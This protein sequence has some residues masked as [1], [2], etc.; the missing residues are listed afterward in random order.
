MDYVELINEQRRQL[1]D[2]QQAY[3]ALAPA[4]AE[5][6]TLKSLRVVTVKG[7]KYVYEATGTV[8]KSL[9]PATRALLR[10]K[11]ERGARRKA[12]QTRTRTIGKRLD[13]MAPV[14]RALRLGGVRRIVARILRELEREGL[15][16]NNVIVAGTNALHAYE[17]ACGVVINQ[18]HV[19]T[20]DADL[21]WDGRQS[22][23]LAAHGIKRE[24]LLGLLRRVDKSFVADYGLNATNSDGFVVDLLCPETDDYTTMNRGTDLEAT[25]MPGIDWL[26][27]APRFE[28]TIIGEDGLPLRIVVPEPRTFALHKLWVSRVHDRSAAKRPRDVAH[29]KL[30][31]ELV[32]TYMRQPFTSKAMPW[33]P[34]ELRALTKEIVRMAKRTS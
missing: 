30:V 23:F 8:R 5:L 19:S 20:T 28:Q 13:Q 4:A 6:A 25:P 17:T 16:G 22:L 26:L 21:V 2:A 10:E 9:G 29:A 12:L 32:A 1:I 27:A 11:D 14:N 18:E 24:G 34:P 33:L 31:A 3:A 7:R 15:L